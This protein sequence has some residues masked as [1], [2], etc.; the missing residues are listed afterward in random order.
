MTHDPFKETF[1]R[2]LLLSLNSTGGGAKCSFAFG[3]TPLLLAIAWK[4]PFLF[5]CLAPSGPHY[6]G[7]RTPLV[8]LNVEGVWHRRNKAKLVIIHNQNQ[9]L[10]V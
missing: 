10:S 4:P 7:Q 6:Q 9:V 2:I 8:R 1:Q 3:N 5:S